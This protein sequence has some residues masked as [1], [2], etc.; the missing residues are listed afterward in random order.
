MNSKTV[1]SLTAQAAISYSPKPY[2]N[3]YY[4]ECH[5]GILEIAKAFLTMLSNQLVN[6]TMVAAYAKRQ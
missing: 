3:S 4:N 5:E 2:H 6:K 1:G